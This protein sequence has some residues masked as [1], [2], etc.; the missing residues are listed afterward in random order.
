VTFLRVLIVLAAVAL[1]MLVVLY[2]LT[3]NPRYLNIAWQMV[4]I[5]GIALLIVGALVLLERFVLV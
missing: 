4:K 3:R 1:G 2:I 5:G